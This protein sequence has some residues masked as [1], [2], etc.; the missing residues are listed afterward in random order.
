M[1][2]SRKHL[3]MIQFALGRY[4]DELTTLF[5]PEELICGHA[6]SVAEWIELREMIGQLLLKQ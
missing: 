2:I 4:I 6:K 1:D 5:I 3:E